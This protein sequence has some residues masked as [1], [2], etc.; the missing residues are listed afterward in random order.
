MSNYEIKPITRYH[1]VIEIATGRS[2]GSFQNEEDALYLKELLDR[3]DKNL[4]VLAAESKVQFDGLTSALAESR[5]QFDN[6]TAASSRSVETSRAR[7]TEL[8]N[9]VEN[10]RTTFSSA[11]ETLEVRA[12]SNRESVK[13]VVESLNK[14][15]DNHQRTISY[16]R[17]CRA[18][19]EKVS[20]G[21]F[22][23][24]TMCGPAREW[25]EKEELPWNT[26]SSS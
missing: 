21:W 9:I 12:N 16:A 25:L 20:A 1:R 10:Q 2:L 15:R 8:E 4:Q 17:S 22:S 19:L 3:K 23:A 13:G 5:A 7:I 18:L 24:I 6:L 26:S 14:E 11:L